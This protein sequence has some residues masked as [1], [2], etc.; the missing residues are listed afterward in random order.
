MSWGAF[1]IRQSIMGDMECVFEL[2]NVASA[3]LEIIEEQQHKT[4]D[5]GKDWCTRN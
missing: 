5:G 3:P 4:A 1:G 2:I